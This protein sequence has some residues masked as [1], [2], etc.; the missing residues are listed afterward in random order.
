[1]PVAQTPEQSSDV[2]LNFRLDPV[3]FVRQVLGRD[4][5]EMQDTILR[6]L[7][8]PN[9]RVAIKSCHASG[10]TQISADIS[11]WHTA[12]GGI[13][14]TTAPSWTQV[15]AQ[16]WGYIHKTYDG[17]KD[18][19]GG[20]LLKTEWNVTSNVF[21]RGLSTNE[22]VRFQGFHGQV[23]VIL[24]EALG[25]RPDIW[26][27]IEGI[28]AGGD[29]RVLA[30]GN[31]TLASGPFYDAFRNTRSGWITHTISAFDTPNLSNIPGDTH[32]QKLQNLLAMDPKPGGPLDDNIRPYLT[33]RRWVYE[34]YHE[35]G[36]DSPLWYSRVIGEFPPQSDDSLISVSWLDQARTK[37]GSTSGLD[38]FHSGIDVA[39]P[40]ESETVCVVR[41]GTKILDIQSWTKPDPRNEVI[42]MLAYWQ[43][44]SHNR[45]SLK[46]NVDSA[47][48]GWY[49]YKHLQDKGFDVNPVNVGSGVA[50]DISNK[51]KYVR[52]KDQ[53]YWQL[54]ELFR[55]GL[56]TNLQDDLTAGQLAAI[57]YSQDTRNRI[58]IESKE[59]MAKRGVASPDRAE[60][61]MLAFTEAPTEAGKLFTPVLL[62]GSIAGGW[63]DVAVGPFES[64]SKKD[65]IIVRR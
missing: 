26:E 11:L 21:A 44:R 39:G 52:L 59:A 37:F 42:Q 6:E 54:R 5:W 13:T 63:T 57:R 53:L 22:G 28:R 23:L 2:L 64:R 8:V 55:D 51:E 27:A 7:A 49:F 3:K 41:H 31:P 17:K 62:H 33:K 40:G 1:V 43:F 38:E 15:E 58:V 24:D 9:A 60:A 50:G 56:V 25:V 45:N 34:K 46:V 32:Q 48:N 14:L 4:T 35:W 20:D 36:P 30:L 18:I 19:L 29:V 12:T 65:R 61:L 10:K 47:G 16:L